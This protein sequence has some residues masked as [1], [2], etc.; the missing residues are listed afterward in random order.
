MFLRTDALEQ[1]TMHAVDRLQQRP[2]FGGFPFANDA[3]TLLALAGNKLTHSEATLLI[4][5]FNYAL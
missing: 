4:Q 5:P 1:W 3:K 2:A